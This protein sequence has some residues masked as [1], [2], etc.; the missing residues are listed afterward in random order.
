EGKLEGKASILQHLLI[1]K[2]GP[3][4]EETQCRLSTATLDQLDLWAE[5]LLDAP[6]LSAIFDEH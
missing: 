4:P 5:R 1:K 2:F 3:L 6:T